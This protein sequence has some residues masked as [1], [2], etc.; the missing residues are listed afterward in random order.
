VLG[1]HVPGSRAEEVE[2]IV[3]RGKK[4]RRR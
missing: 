3:G 2:T 1:I 4:E